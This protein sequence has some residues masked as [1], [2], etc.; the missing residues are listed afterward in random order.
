VIIVTHDLDTIKSALDRFIVLQN[1]KICFDG[2][3]DAA[4]NSD[5]A[6]LKE[7]LKAN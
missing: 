1:K 7:F 4:I 6:F 2:T 3:Y 5:M